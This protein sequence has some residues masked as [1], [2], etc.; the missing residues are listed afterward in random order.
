MS[1]D[2]KKVGTG[3]DRRSFLEG[4]AAG[5][6]GAA[7]MA[8]AFAQN[9]AAPVGGETRDQLR[10]DMLAAIEDDIKKDLDLRSK[11]A[12][13]LPRPKNLRAGGMLDARFP[14]YYKTSVP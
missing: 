4:A 3:S 6:L 7:A 1:A 12:E 10:Q 9:A 11:A 2:D 5:L 13:E 8:P 14:V